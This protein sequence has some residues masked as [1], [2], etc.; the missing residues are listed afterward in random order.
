MAINLFFPTSNRLIN[1]TGTEREQLLKDIK[2]PYFKG[3]IVMPRTKIIFKNN[4][5]R[6]KF[7]LIICKEYL[8]SVSIVFYTQKNFYL[9][10]AINEKISLFSAFGLIQHWHSYDRIISYADEKPPQILNFHHL[11]GAFQILLGG[12]CIS[13]LIFIAEIASKCKWKFLKIL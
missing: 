7:Q 6:D 11:Q 4:N 9:T 3:A 1:V 10:S 8:V 5:N 13:A 2:S 12:L